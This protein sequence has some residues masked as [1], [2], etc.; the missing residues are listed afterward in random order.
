MNLVN[1]I[2]PRFELDA[3][4][5]QESVV[6]ADPKVTLFGLREGSRGGVDDTVL[7]PPRRV[8]VLS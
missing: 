3:I 1:A 5:A 7:Q 6:G 4:E 2:V 8:S